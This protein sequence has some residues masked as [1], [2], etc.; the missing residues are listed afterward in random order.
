V[1]QALIDTDI[2]SLPRYIASLRAIHI[3]GHTVKMEPP[4]TS[5]LLSLAAI[6]T[7]GMTL[8]ADSL[9]ANSLTTS[10]PGV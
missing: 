4:P 7:S 8:I 2:L 9:Y 1:K 3:G 6:A 10:P 5:R